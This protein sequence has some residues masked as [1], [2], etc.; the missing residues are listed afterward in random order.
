MTPDDPFAS[1]P[2]FGSVPASAVIAECLR[3]Q[4]S[5]IPRTAMARLF[6]RSPLSPDSRSWYVGAI[7]EL[8]VARRLAKLGADWTVL[9][10]VPVGT[11]GS[12]IDHV[13]IGPAGAF[14]INTK[15]HTGARIWVGRGRLM[16]NGQKTDHL[17]NAR[18][19]ALRAQSLLTAATG[20]TVVAH[21]VVV[22]V[23]ASSVTR[24]G[25]PDGVS[26]IEAPQLVRWLTKQKQSLDPSTRSL[27]AKAAGADATWSS[28]PG[29]VADEPGFDALRRE[30]QAARRIRLAWAAALVI[31]A[32][33]IGAPFVINAYVQL[34]G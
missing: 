14:T 33:G 15:R 10:S 24:K 29:P 16:V 12:D 1:H 21:G 11:R 23:G 3:L 31:A 8:E 2:A 9:H 34:T 18:H 13:V 17:R 5:A 30:V 22:I 20:A 32:V 19:E 27:I 25:Q 6:G 7:G 4:N 28:I 26:V